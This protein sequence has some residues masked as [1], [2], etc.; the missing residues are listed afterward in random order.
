MKVTINSINESLKK[1]FKKES[2]FYNFF[3]FFWETI[4]A[5]ELTDNWHIEYLCNEL[6][7][8]GE[9]VA[10]RLPKEYDYYI[11]NIPPG[12]SK[13]TIISEMYPLW[14][15]TIDPSQR[16]ICASSSSTIAEDIADKCYKIYTSEV[17]REFY[18][19]LTKKSTGGKTNFK[20]GLKGERYT[21]S[22]SSAITGIHAHQKILDDILGSR[23][24]NSQSERSGVNKW[25]KETISSRNVNAE[26]TTTILVM[27][28]LH[29]DDPT[30]HLLAN[31]ELKIKHICIP[32]E[33]SEDVS[34]KELR[35]FYKD[36]L[37]DPKRKPRHILQVAKSDYGSYGYAGQMM[38][39]PSP[40]GGGLLKK[41]WFQIIDKPYPMEVV[42]NFQIDSAYTE[43]TA[44]DPTAIIGYYEYQNQ[45]FITSVISIYKEFP[46]LVLWLP[47]YFRQNG[48][49]AR[50]VIY[51]EP[52]A[53]GLSIV[54]QIKKTTNLNI[55]TSEP[56][57]DDKI[58]RAH[59]SSP[60]IESGRVSL[61]FA[62]WNGG[63]INQCTSFPK[64]LHDDEVDCLTAIVIRELIKGNDFQDLSEELSSFY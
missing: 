13:S 62:G 46:D 58:T 41:E 11:I 25:L 27:Q 1:S 49:S 17:F 3:C 7:Y 15:W 34:P 36:G 44:N 31:K 18:P 22:S 33:L 24:A 38:Q 54:Q 12:S 37:F 40:D 5:E 21:T 6:Q 55:K 53:S 50:S 57:K 8:I 19:E 39:R 30:G 64:G 52:K 14:C 9:R 2:G 10:K 29:E 43:N 51:T 28:R 4:I 45:I 26:I 35:S 20:N 23:E 56:P 48:Y 59:I 32:A 42:I 61:H 63:F 16:F 47:E 60:K